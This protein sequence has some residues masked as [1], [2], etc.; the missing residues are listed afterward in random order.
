M[1]N[2]LPV[3]LSKNVLECA[4]ELV[5]VRWIG[6]RLAILSLVVLVSFNYKKVQCLRFPNKKEGMNN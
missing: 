3:F 1:L 5:G 4:A 6:R 2:I